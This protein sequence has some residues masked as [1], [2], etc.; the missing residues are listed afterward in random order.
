[1]KNPEDRASFES[2]GAVLPGLCFQM[3]AFALKRILVMLM[4]HLIH[5]LLCVRIVA[6]VMD[7]VLISFS[8]ADGTTQEIGCT[9]DS[10][11]TTE[12]VE[13]RTPP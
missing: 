3:H 10:N 1:M 12:D 4:V 6:E 9:D 13:H 8:Q 11:D 7:G 2:R 5:G